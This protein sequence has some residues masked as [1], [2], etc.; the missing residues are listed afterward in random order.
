M[1]SPGAASAASAAGEAH[2]LTAVT[3]AAGLLQVMGDS[4]LLA[5]IVA[6][7]T[8]HVASPGS[9][10]SGALQALLDKGYEAACR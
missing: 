8:Q 6:Q 3:L 9:A 10:K 5:A 4:D 7:C 1:H 2:D